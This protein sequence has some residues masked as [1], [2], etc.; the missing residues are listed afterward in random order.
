MG[1]W[2]QQHIVCARKINQSVFWSI[3]QSA[4]VFHGDAFFC[5][6]PCD[7]LDF[8]EMSYIRF[9]KMWYVTIK[10]NYCFS[11]VYLVHIKEER[12]SSADTEQNINVCVFR[13]QPALFS[14][15]AFLRS[16]YIL[17]ATAGTTGIPVVNLRSRN[18]K[19]TQMMRVTQEQQHST[20]EAVKLQQ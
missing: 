19:Q 8:R 11:P 15:T 12:K 3:Q 4:S 10:M 16:T 9:Y 14:S 5:S 20:A 1:Q 7:G 6:L 2:R 17:W 13:K 18:T